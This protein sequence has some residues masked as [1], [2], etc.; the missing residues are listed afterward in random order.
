MN[1]IKFAVIILLI[2]GM[3]MSYTRVNWQD[4]PSVATPVNAENLNKMDKG[5]ADLNNNLSGLNDHLKG[6]SAKK[7]AFVAFLDDDFTGPLALEKCL[8]LFELEGIPLN[9]AVVTSEM[10]SSPQKIDQ[11]ER[12]DN[13]G[14]SIC[15]HT[16]DH[17]YLSLDYVSKEVIRNDIEISKQ[18]L[19][20][21]GYNHNIIVYPY[22]VLDAYAESIVRENYDY[23]VL[24]GGGANTYDKTFSNYR[25]RR[26][27][28]PG[29]Q[30]TTLNDYKQHVLEVKE[31]GGLLVFMTHIKSVP[32][33]DAFIRQDMVDLIDFIRTQDIEITSLRHAFEEMNSPLDVAN[34]FGDYF[35][36]SQQGVVNWSGA[37]SR[38]IVRNDKTANN[39]TPITDF[40]K[41]TLAIDTYLSNDERGFPERA[42][43]LKTY[44]VHGDLFSVQEFITSTNV[45]YTRVIGANG[46]WS[47]WRRVSRTRTMT[48]ASSVD[49][50]TIPSKGSKTVSITM[51]GATNGGGF[52]VTPVNGMA[53]QLMLYA[54]SDSPDTVKITAFNP[55]DYGVTFSRYFHIWEVY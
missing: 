20:S 26:A 10:S 27:F 6:R 54:H 14:G 28:G 12:I 35:S 48:T 1:K 21:K 36:V 47:P 2:G 51:N 44:R 32:D 15:S 34:E 8:S 37:E 43:T 16:H 25:I 31:K 18:V 55:L 33:W 7:K 11:L 52:T 3:I 29:E 13:L 19:E 42:G 38:I 30:G 9:V 40:P 39:A 24:A 17:N 46:E 22:G 50:G 49:F 41:K 5:I 23:G 45:V 53:H 4:K